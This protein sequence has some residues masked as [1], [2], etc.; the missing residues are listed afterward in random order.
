MPDL[1]D[2]SRFTPEER[3]ALALDLLYLILRDSG[4]N[5]TTLGA[6]NAAG[7]NAG[8]EAIHSLFGESQTKGEI[9]TRAR[10]IRSKSGGNIDIFAPGGGV[11]LATTAFGTPLAPPGILTEDGGNISI[12]AQGNVDIGVSRIFTLRGGNIVIWSSEG[13]IAAGSSPKTV[14]TAPPTRV[15]IDPQSADVETDL[16]GLATGGGIGVLA[17]VGDVTPGNVD[18]IAPAGTVDAGDAGIRATGNLNIAAVQVLN[19]DNIQVSGTS[20]GTPV[21]AAVAAPNLAGLSASSNAAAAATNAAQE[22]ARQNPQAASGQDEVPSI[23]VVELLG[24]GETPSE[25]GAGN[26]GS[27][28]CRRVPVRWANGATNWPLAQLSG[29]RIPDLRV[30][31]VAMGSLLIRLATSGALFRFIVLRVVPV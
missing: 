11:T 14:Q 24:Y 19:A 4:R 7:Y 21:A 9:F 6:T 16:A 1:S 27:R 22:T 3:S 15:L 5:S 31:D 20:A 26:S 13:D 23:I 12:F 10:D 18:L 30:R 25:T 2:L 29:Q 28:L 17:T 8:F